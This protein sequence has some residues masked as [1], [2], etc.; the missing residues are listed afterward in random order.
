[1]L[2]IL[3][4]YFLLECIIILWLWCLYAWF[5][6]TKLV[7]QYETFWFL[8]GQCVGI[9]YIVKQYNLWRNITQ[10][11]KLQFTTMSD[12]T[13]KCSDIFK[14]GQTLLHIQHIVKCVMTPKATIHTLKAIYVPQLEPAQYHVALSVFYIWSGVS[15]GQT[16]SLNKVKVGQTFAKN[17]RKMSDVRP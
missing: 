9:V 2:Y 1:M 10:S 8:K 3:Q 12:R 6:L 11:L 4:M 13:L 5:Y 17:G 14:Y 7:V 15:N 16:F